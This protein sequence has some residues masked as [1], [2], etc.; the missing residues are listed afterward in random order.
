[1]NNEELLW[2]YIDGE[3]SPEEAARVKRLMEENLSLKKEWAQRLKLHQ[4]LQQ[5]EAEQPS[6]RFTRNVM[7]RL[8]ELYRKLNISPLISPF[9]RKALSGVAGIF[10]LA[11]FAL[12]FN[13]IET[14]PPGSAPQYPEVDTFVNT[15][16]GLPMQ[17]MSI[18]LALSLGFVLLSFADR[19]LK[20]R[21][22]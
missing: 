3:C 11:Y 13:V 17:V 21:F 2:K 9:W 8:P 19:K 20:K 16:T 22:G 15:L 5:Q 4:E 10:L 18:V 14:A 6:M 1:M 7:D 12:A